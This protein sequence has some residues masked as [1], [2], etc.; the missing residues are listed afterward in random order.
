MK[1]NLPNVVN[2]DNSVV[3]TPA[4]SL[5]VENENRDTGF[6]YENA[7]LNAD[8]KSLSLF[9]GSNVSLKNIYKYAT[10]ISE[11]V[12]ATIAGYMNHISTDSWPYF[13]FFAH[14]ENPAPIIGPTKN[15]MEK[16]MPISAIPLFLVLAVEISVTIAVDNVTLPFDSPPKI[17]KNVFVAS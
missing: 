8:F 7:C 1:Y 12:R 5:S 2:D 13:L 16:A 11:S 14:T 9:S 4:L 17:I 15:P 6:I 10:S 3:L